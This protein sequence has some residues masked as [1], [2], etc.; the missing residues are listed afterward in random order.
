LLYHNVQVMA[1]SLRFIDAAVAVLAS[2]VLVWYG[3]EGGAP[4][5]EHYRFAV[6]L[7]GIAN[8]IAFMIIAERMRIYFARRTEDIAGELLAVSEVGLYAGCIAAVATEI[9]GG[10]LPPYSYLQ[11]LGAALFA[12][13]AMRFVMRHTIRRLRRRGDDYRIWLIVGHNDRAANLAETVAAN[14][15]FGIRIAEIVDIDDGS[16]ADSPER[17]HFDAHPPHGVKLRVVR[18]VEEI[19]EAVCSRV[20]D[21]RVVDEVVVTLPMRS[22]YDTVSRILEICC[23]AGISVRIRPQA[24][25]VLGY[26][27]EVSHVGKIAMLTHYNGPSNYWQLLIKRVL[28]VLGAGIGLVLLSPL[29]AA[30]A[31]AIKATSPGPVLFR[32]VRVGLHGRHFQL[33][34]FRSM[35][36][37]ALQIREQLDEK[38]ERDGKAFKI[39]NDARITPLGKWLRKYR[40]DELPQ[41]WNVLVGD[42]SLV[43]PRP[44]PATEAVG[45]E[46]WHRRRHSMPPGLTGLWQVEDDPKMPL[47]QWMELDMAYID[48]WSIWL[49]LKLIA[50]TFATVVRGNG[51]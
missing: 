3:I 13:P 28:D 30:V 35:V 19:R 10:G 41:L 6:E 48:R 12:L 21:E 25:E 26:D 20:I 7:F 43:G 36:K 50:R 23:E 24:F 9:W 51:W 18:S 16:R 8:L 31:I 5:R 15:H 33:I 22:H 47:R 32:Q 14:P 29:L 46:W 2:T 27:T 17:R 44:F 38:N 42:M 11:A 49:D 39:R 4:M 45:F 34:K 37:N 40:I 1:Y